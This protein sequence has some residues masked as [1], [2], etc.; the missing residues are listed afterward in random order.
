MGQLCPQDGGASQ[1]EPARG[2]YQQEIVGRFRKIPARELAMA[3]WLYREGHVTHRQLRVYFAAHEMAERRRCAAPRRG[4]AANHAY[5]GL[6]EVKKLV[7]GRGSP[8]AEAEL[9]GDLRALARIGL[10]TLTD[11]S[12]TFAKGAGDLSVADTS[13][14]A[15]MLEALPHQHR[16]VPVP[17]RTLRALAAG[18]SRTVTAVVI[19]L[20]IRS[21]FWRREEARYRT[22]GRTKLSWITEVFGVSRRAVT[23]ARSH[24]V[25]IG[26][27]EPIEENQWAL[28]RWGLHD[29]INAD[30]K[31]GKEGATRPVD[32]SVAVPTNDNAESASP[33]LAIDRENASPESNKKT[34]YENFNTRKPGGGPSPRS[35][36]SRKRE[37]G[38]ST[39]PPRLSDIRFPDLRDTG[40]LLDLHRQAVDKGLASSSEAGELEF[41]SLAERAIAR[42]RNPGA[43]FAWL[44]RGQRTAFITQADEDRAVTRLQ[45][46]KHGRRYET[47]EPVIFPES[48]SLTEAEFF[49]EKCISVAKRCG[50]IDPYHVASQLKGWS[51]EEWALQHSAYEIKER[52][53]RMLRDWNFRVEDA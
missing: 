1:P 16:S 14:Y 49:V 25:D 53:R 12:I 20:L 22:D 50:R 40:R 4:A 24:L 11:S 45:E 34:S 28:N 15:T 32:N 42:A 31:A 17:R 3:W 44:L 26:W 43:M 48:R 21:L 51:R 8:R 5:Y 13:G 7:G 41:V 37:E 23:Q 9:A 30:W 38:R 33:P 19:A 2:L 46:H 47:K 18:F 39:K 29:R 6:A 52:R 10:V 36:F 27:L 35:G